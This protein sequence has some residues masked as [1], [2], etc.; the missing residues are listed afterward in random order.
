M[1]THRSPRRRAPWPIQRG[2]SSGR[3]RRAG[4]SRAAALRDGVQPLADGLGLLADVVQAGKR[5]QALE[6]EHALEERLEPVADRSAGAV[7]PAGLGDQA[8][9]EEARDRRVG[10]DAADAGDLGPA[11]R[12]RGRR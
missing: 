10:G 4:R 2:C 11:A 3:R 5:G 6:P 8:A 9:L 1:K 7:V 12:A